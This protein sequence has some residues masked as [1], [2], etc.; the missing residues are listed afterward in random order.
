MFGQRQGTDALASGGEDGVAYG[1][2]DW[3]K[4][5]FAEPRRRVVG[6]QEVN[7]D[8]GRHFIDAHGRIFVEIA[9]H[10]TPAVDSDLVAHDRA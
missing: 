7:F 5:G 9:L 1:W 3:R 6:L 8:F 2:Q 4:R 10:G